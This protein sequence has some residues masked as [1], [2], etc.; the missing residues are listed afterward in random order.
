MVA[1]RAV[2]RSVA[3]R[4]LLLAVALWPMATAIAQSA[5]DD[6]VQARTLDT[7][8][9]TGSR[10][11]APAT[12]LARNVA[13]LDAA[14]IERRAASSMFDLLR[15]LAGLHV[16]RAGV[17]GFSGVYLRGADPNHT[18]VLIDGMKVNDP[19]NSRGGGFDFATLHPDSIGRIEVLPGAV[20]AVHGA[21]AMA[22]VISINSPGFGD[23]S[24]DGR[25]RAGLGGHGY[26]NL[27]LRQ[28]WCRPTFGAGAF[29]ST[30]HDDGAAGSSL[31]SHAAG[32]ALRSEAAGDTTVALSLRAQ[33]SD[34][35]VFPDD[36][37]GARYA[38]IRELESRAYGQAWG[39]LV[40]GR[41]FARGQLNARLS[42][43]DLS[44]RTDSPGVAPGPRDPAGLPAF[45]TDDRLE[46]TAMELSWRTETRGGTALLF[47]AASDQDRGGSHGQLSFGGFVL[48]TDFQATLTTRALFAELRTPSRHPLQAQLGLRHD[49]SAGYGAAYLARIAGL[50]ARRLARHLA[51]QRRHRLQAAELLRAGAS[52]RRQSATAA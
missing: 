29:A 22:G 30:M 6:T 9:V 36:S 16:D 48:P 24:D 38:Q 19:L 11:S 7:I 13:V 44:L 15:P 35:E 26:R 20:S 31:R 27:A 37:G 39:T 50:R 3:K 33:R 18:L 34:M 28:A 21:D 8:V 10:L 2:P 5:P 17:G 49:D 45:T 4:A 51:A 52:D 14:A 42:Y 12:P 47:G 40:V 32:V 25:A 46:R 43:A 41:S 1:L 23:C